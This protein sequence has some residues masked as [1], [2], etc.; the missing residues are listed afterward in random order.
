MLSMDTGNTCIYQLYIPCI[1]ISMYMYMYPCIAIGIALMTSAGG[2]PAGA[3]HPAGEALHRDR[4]REPVG[5][6][7]HP[8]APERYHHKLHYI[9][10]M[11]YDI[12]ELLHH[13][14]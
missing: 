12:I 4:G 13:T 7:P 5:Q 8:L 9:C 2:A 1:Y 14:A 11:L 3:R 10:Y 6:L